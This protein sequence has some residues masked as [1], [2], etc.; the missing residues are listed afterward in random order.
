MFDKL[1]V[2]FLTEEVVGGFFV[3]VH[4]GQVAAVYD[5]F[6]G[7]LKNTWGP[8]LHFKLPFIQKVKKFNTQ[9]LEYTIRDGFNAEEN[10]EIL[11]D[12]AF[13]V[14][15]ADGVSV[16]LYGT[17]LVRI[18]KES[19]VGMWENIGEGFI[20]KI[21]R[22]VSRSRIRTAVSEFTFQQLHTSERHNAEKRIKELLELEFQPKG[23]IV[24][25]VLLSEINQTSPSPNNP[26]MR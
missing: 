17:I 25:G 12:D 16:Q 15:T 14:V 13:N 22:P 24:E 19:V 4:P 9:T 10:K 11:G 1:V 26:E 23:L 7:V 18:N 8:G 5:R 21:V 6:R 3:D 2:S 20:S